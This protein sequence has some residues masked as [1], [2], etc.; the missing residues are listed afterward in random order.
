MPI[1]VIVLYDAHDR[2][3]G[4]Y[5]DTKQAPD[6]TCRVEQRQA[7][8][9]DEGMVALLDKEYDRVP[10]NQSLSEYE[11]KIKERALSKLTAQERRALGVEM[12]PPPDDPNARVMPTTASYANEPKPAEP[13]TTWKDI[14]TK[15]LGATEAEREQF[16]SFLDRIDD[17]L[18]I[19]AKK[20]QFDNTEANLTLVQDVI[21]WLDLDPQAK[22]DRFEGWSEGIQVD[23]THFWAPI[24]DAELFTYLRQRMG[25]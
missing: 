25:S 20:V 21:D 8:Y 4:V 7:V 9:V 10:L 12:P 13:E 18:S 5:S 16:T 17:R 19:D 15:F 6:A 22:A 23:D 1:Q 2:V 14:H 3:T 11:R 24:L